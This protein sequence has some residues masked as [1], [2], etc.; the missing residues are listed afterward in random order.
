[1]KTLA[2][3][4]LLAALCSAASIA[5]YD[6]LVLRPATAIAVIDAAL[7]YQDMQARLLDRAL[8]G[9]GLRDVLERNRQFQARFRQEL[10]RLA[11]DCHCLL[12]D[13]AAIVGLRPQV[14]DLT[15]QLRQRMQ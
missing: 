8:A 14:A 2:L 6:R 13:K 7:V 4:L 1:M 9:G 12:L 5:L 15:P 11:D 10:A 3:Q